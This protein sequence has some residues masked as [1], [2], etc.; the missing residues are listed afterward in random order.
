MAGGYKDEVP[1]LDA[2]SQ[3]SDDCK[4]LELQRINTRSTT[5][6]TVRSAS[7]SMSMNAVGSFDNENYLVSHTGP[8]RSERRTPFIPM[9][10]PLYSNRKPDDLFRTMNGILGGNPPTGML[11]GFSSVK[12]IDQMDWPE[13][14][15]AGK[16]VHLLRSGPLGICN[17]PYCT[18]CPT[19]YHFKPAAQ[20]HSKAF[21]SKVTFCPLPNCTF[22]S[23]CLCLLL[24]SS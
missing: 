7:M 21:D 6:S 1:M 5:R 24:L 3:L 19:N 14:N 12:G 17:D 2:R 9:S 10:G 20:K 13:D 23:S 11:E 8:L 22:L 18:S 16:N 4:D 15:F